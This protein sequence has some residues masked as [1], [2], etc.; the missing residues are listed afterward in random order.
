MRGYEGQKGAWR[1]F[2]RRDL[3]PTSNRSVY[4]NNIT[5]QG[6]EGLITQ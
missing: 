5:V 1:I 2:G 3:K 6:L 4:G